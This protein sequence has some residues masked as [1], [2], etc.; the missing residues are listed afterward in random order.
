VSRGEKKGEIG[1]EARPWWTVLAKTAS[2]ERV[3]KAAAAASI[4]GEER[5]D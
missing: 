1:Q 3:E 2:A 4:C 5:R